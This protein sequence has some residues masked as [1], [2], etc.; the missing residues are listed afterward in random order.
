MGLIHLLRFGA[1]GHVGRFASADA[2]RYP[3]GTRVIVRTSRGLESAV[4]LAHA[5]RA[6]TG[7]PEGTILRGMTVEDDLLH[8]RLAKGRDAALAACEVRLRERGLADTLLDVEH[9]F[10]GETL[11][12]HFL[13]EPSIAARDLTAELAE[14]YEAKIQFRKF[15]EAVTT[16]CG[17][18]C[19]TEEAGGCGTACSTGCAIAGACG[20]KGRPQ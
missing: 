3:R 9:L 4:V 18:G 20:T 15:A 17:P 14:L 2:A 19:G 13:G 12:F 6:T 10:D 7:D 1:L 16:G 11:V 5:D 8:A